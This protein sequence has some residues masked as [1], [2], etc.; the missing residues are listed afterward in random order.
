MDGQSRRFDVMEIRRPDGLSDIANLSDQA[1]EGG[2]T[3]DEAKH[4]LVRV[5]QEAVAAQARHHA[6]FRPDCQSCGG[7]CHMKDWRRH[8]VATL[9]GEVRVKRPRLVGAGRRLPR[10]AA[11]RIHDV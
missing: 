10:M 11:G 1:R 7:R 3:L 8:R 4:R 6:I 2:L 9:F 5:Q